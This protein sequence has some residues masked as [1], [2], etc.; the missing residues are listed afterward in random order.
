[1]YVCCKCGS[2]SKLARRL[3]TRPPVIENKSPRFRLSYGSFANELNLWPQRGRLSWLCIFTSKLNHW[4][5]YESKEVHNLGP[6]SLPICLWAERGLRWLGRLRG[7]DEFF[8]ILQ[9][10]WQR[11]YWH[12]TLINTLLSKYWLRFNWRNDGE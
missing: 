9:F 5:N 3:T 7:T 4:V 1:M 6:V 11:L 8:F 2:V 12:N 10:L